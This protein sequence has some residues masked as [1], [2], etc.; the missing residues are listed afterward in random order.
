[1]GIKHLII[2]EMKRYLKLFIFFAIGIVFISLTSKAQSDFGKDWKLRKDLPVFSEPEI[3]SIQANIYQ[4]SDKV[5]LTFVLSEKSDVASVKCKLSF[6]PVYFFVVGMPVLLN[7]KTKEK[8]EIDYEFKNERIIFDKVTLDKNLKYIEFGVASRKLKNLGTLLTTEEK[9]KQARTIRRIKQQLDSWSPL[10]ADQIIAQPTLRPIISHGGYA[11]DGVKRAVIWANDTKL[12][13]KFEIIDALNNVQHP[14]PQPVVYTGDLIEAGNHIWGGN[15]YIADFSDFK[16]EGLYFVRLKV[17]ETKEISDSYVFLIKKNIYLDLATKAAKWFYYQRCGT[18]VEGFHKACHT[19]DAIIKTNGTKVDVTG[20]WHD[21]G[22]YGKWMWGGSMG[23]FGLTTFQND[24]GTEL[25]DSLEGMPRY[26]N[27]IAWEAEYFCKTYWD[28][29]FHPGFT[30]NFENVCMWIGAPENEPPR[31]VSE[32]ECIENNYGIIKGAA[33]CLPGLVLARAGRLLLPYNKEL[34]EKCL[35]IA[36]DVYKR[37]IKMENPNLYYIE[38]GLLQID[39]ELYQVYHD[40]K[41]MKDARQRVKNIL[42]LQDKDGLFYSDNTK[43]TK[44]TEP[45]MHLPALYE[46][47]KRN[48]DSEL[49]PEIKNAFKLWADYSMQYANLSPFGQIG[50]IAKDGST[51]NIVPH[52]N[53][54]K[55]GDVAWALATTAILLEEPKYLE[56]AEYQIQWIV[57]FNPA[58]VST[59]SDVGK[60]PGC[61]H[62]RYSFTEGGRSGVVPGGVMIGIN[63]GNGGILELGDITK[64]FII[65]EVPIDYP[66][67]DTGTWGWTYAYKTSEYAC[68]KNDSFIR[69]ASQITKALRKLK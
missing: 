42:E 39:L 22:D 55:M 19:E 8:N 7:A 27:E 15:N 33:I 23:L 44:V 61:Y 67:F 21:A 58:D 13:G 34:A 53:N 46:F 20:G 49:A 47:I 38:S 10:A 18:E 52:T 5:R 66:I 54:R 48:P 14:D 41:Y 37:A 24:F 3:K 36:K 32:Q 16:K 31:I 60:G 59:M 65:A 30:P 50:G 51:R 57:G 2:F 6:D 1:M 29:E 68:S 35:A 11:V 26:I 56:A 43:T 12:T 9:I 40:E 25:T 62:H 17:N 64:N 63:P 69:G 4:N 45:R 28:G